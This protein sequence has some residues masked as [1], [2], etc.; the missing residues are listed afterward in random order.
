MIHENKRTDHSAKTE[1]K[2]AFYFYCLA[3]S[4][5]PGFNYDVKHKMIFSFMNLS[6]N[7]QGHK[8]ISFIKGLLRCFFGLMT[9][10]KAGKLTCSTFIMSL[11][12]YFLRHY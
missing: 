4:S 3:D 7:I 2:N 1:R 5:T 11:L 6:F 8:I 9:W 12:A 10:F